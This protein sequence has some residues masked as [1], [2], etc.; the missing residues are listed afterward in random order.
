[1][2]ACPPALPQPQSD[3]DSWAPVLLHQAHPSEVAALGESPALSLAVHYDLPVCL[4]FLIL[5][6]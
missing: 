5:A 4:Q 1:M 2:L 6:A 3:T